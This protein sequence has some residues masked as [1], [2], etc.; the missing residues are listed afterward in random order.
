M[1]EPLACDRAAVRAHGSP[2]AL[3]AQVAVDAT[4]ATVITPVCSVIAAVVAAVAA[5]VAAVSAIVAPVSICIGEPTPQ[6]QSHQCI[7]NRSHVPSVILIMAQRWTVR[8]QFGD[9]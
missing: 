8:Y 6:R 1:V 7:N 2:V 5:V 3:T 9:W 4:V